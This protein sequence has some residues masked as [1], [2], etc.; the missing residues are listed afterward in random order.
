MATVIVQNFR[1]AEAALK[2]YDDPIYKR[3]REILP[4]RLY[5]R[6]ERFIPLGRSDVALEEIRIRNGR[7]VYLTLGGSA[8]KQNFS[9]DTVI[10]SDEI[11][12]I[13]EKMCDGSLYTYSDSIVKGYV[14]IGAGIRVGICGRAST[15]NGRILGVYNIS[16]LNIRIPHAPIIL[17]EKL[18]KPIR[19]CLSKASGVLI[20]SPPAQGKTTMLRSLCAMLSSGESPMRV[21]LVDSRDEMGDFSGEQKLSVDFLR[22]YPKAEGIAI[23]TAFM[24]PEVIICDEIGSEDEAR[25]IAAAQNCGVPLVASAHGSDITSV[26]RRPSIL[27]LHR[28]HTFGLYVGIRISSSGGFEYS[29]CTREEAEKL[30]EDGRDCGTRF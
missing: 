12:D 11:A 9:L 21:S 2:A 29:F 14:S 6:I 17:E 28:R 27:E 4:P 19:E 1:G 24:N 3:L 20:F 5:L 13:F 8:Q 7:Q 22:G 30:L 16:A 10:S 15:E 23:A 25:S 26:L 18:Y